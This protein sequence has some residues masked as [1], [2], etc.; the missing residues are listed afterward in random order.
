MSATSAEPDQR[1]WKGDNNR[2]A[3]TLNCHLYTWSIGAPYIDRLCKNILG[4]FCNTWVGGANKVIGRE[5][6][7]YFELAHRCLLLKKYAPDDFI[8]SQLRCPYSLR[9]RKPFHLTCNGGF[10]PAVAGVDKCSTPWLAL[11]NLSAHIF[12]CRAQARWYR[13]FILLTFERE[14][15]ERHVRW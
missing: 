11:F 8:M 13:D 3:F 2:A 6:G 7:W 1:P 4:S 12:T 15:S 5:S 10:C 14:R 9:L